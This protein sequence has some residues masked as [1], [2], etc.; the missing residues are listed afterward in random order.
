MKTRTLGIALLLT[1]VSAAF[2]TVE[3]PSNEAL[4]ILRKA[5]RDSFPPINLP[6][7]A[8][9]EKDFEREQAAWADRVIVK[10]AL[11][12]IAAKGDVPW[13]KDVEPFLRQAAARVFRNRTSE[14]SRKLEFEGMRLIRA[15]CEDPVVA[16]LAGLLCVQ[17]SGEWRTVWDCATH[18][19]KGWAAIPDCPAVFILHTQIMLGSAWERSGTKAKIPG[20]DAAA[21]AALEIMTRDGS[22][23]PGEDEI[24]LLHLQVAEP[25]INRNREK[26]IKLLPTLKLTDWVRWTVMGEIR[27]NQAWE[28]RGG[29]WA[30]EVTAEGWKGFALHLGQ[31]RELLVKAW[32]ANPKCPAAAARMIT[33]AVAGQPVAGETERTWFDRAIAARCDY[34]QAYEGLIWAYRPRWIGSHEL[35]LSFGKACMDTKRYD[36]NIPSYFA[37][38]CNSIVAEIPDWREFYRRP[39]IAK[40]IIEQSEGWLKEPSREGEK[41]MRQSYLAV[42]T[43]L[44]GDNVKAA[45]A[46][47]ALNGTPLHPDVLLKLEVHKVTEADFRDEVAIGSFP[48]AKDF[49]KASKLYD[50][51]NNDAAEAEFLNI[52][53]KAAADV[54]EIIASKLRIIG[55]EKSF[56]KGEWVKLPTSAGLRDWVQ[57]RGK[58]KVGEDGALINKGDDLPGWLFH[59]AHVGRNFVMKLEFSVDSKEKCCR[60]CDII[61]GSNG[62]IIEPM[63]YV[64]YGQFGKFG[65]EVKFASNYRPPWN[66]SKK[67]IKYE[68]NNKLHLRCKDGKITFTINGQAACTDQVLEGMNF[69]AGNAR[70]GIGN[71]RWCAKNTTTIRNIQIRRPPE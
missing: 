49:A 7:D 37:K 67:G 62:N 44:T 63:N 36:T 11:A 69:G 66:F 31:A 51:G 40:R 58:W 16:M 35:M 50:E 26:I 42:N 34:R 15:N 47:K 57:S 32:K 22:F 23:L 24:L 5:A 52:Q 10:P 4:E 54:G 71:M 19:E 65:P 68:E 46:L 48:L 27:I 3:I 8:R 6:K 56:A 30:S 38:V 43:W 39:E 17:N 1:L 9:S 13:A 20:T 55:I 18:A 45:E 12:R 14:V 29:G 25:V 64:T 2:S 70:V 59:R 61:F 41:N 60:R 53:P 33:V 28:K 21:L